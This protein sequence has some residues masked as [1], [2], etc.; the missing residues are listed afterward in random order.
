MFFG[1]TIFA[2]TADDIYRGVGLKSLTHGKR[3]CRILC[4]IQ[5]GDLLALPAMQMDVRLFITVEVVEAIADGN[6][7]NV[8]AFP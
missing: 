7:E 2:N 1:N 6:G 3:R 8:A 4:E 5:I